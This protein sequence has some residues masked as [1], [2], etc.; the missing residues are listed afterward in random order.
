MRSTTLLLLSSLFFLAACSGEKS[1]ETGTSGEN[2]PPVGSDRDEHGCIASAG[3]RWCA[4]E[5]ECVRPWEL[6]KEKGFDETPDA[7]DDYC[8][9]T[10][11]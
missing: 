11:E 10:P 4:T 3:Y 8:Q 1:S 5:N 9:N 7:F 2:L 6:A